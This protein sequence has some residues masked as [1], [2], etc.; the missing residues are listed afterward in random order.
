[1]NISGEKQSVNA[2]WILGVRPLCQCCG[3]GEHRKGKTMTKVASYKRSKKARKRRYKD[4]DRTT[5][6]K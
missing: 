6:R 1:M 5:I 2:A 3:G 4:I